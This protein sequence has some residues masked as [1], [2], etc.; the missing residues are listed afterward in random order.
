MVFFDKCVTADFKNLRKYVELAILINVMGQSYDIKTRHKQDFAT[1]LFQFH[2][3]IFWLNILACLLLPTF[4]KQSC[5]KIR[6]S[7][8]SFCISNKHNTEPTKHSCDQKQ[9]NSN[10]L[11]QQWH[12]MPQWWQCCQM[13]HK[14]PQSLFVMPHFCFTYWL[15]TFLNKCIFEIVHIISRNSQFN[16]SSSQKNLWPWVKNFWNPTIHTN[17]LIKGKVINIF[18]QFNVAPTSEWC[19][20]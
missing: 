18:R 12:V 10:C 4:S 2:D 15:V 13:P 14:T 19:A 3:F 20:R 9:T 8:F 6:A 17:T 1:K 5:W 11:T 7:F 16:N